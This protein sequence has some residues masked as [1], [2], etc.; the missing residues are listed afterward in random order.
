MLRSRVDLWCLLLAAWVNGSFACGDN[1]SAQPVQEQ[2]ACISHFDYDKPHWQPKLAA[3]IRTFDGRTDHRVAAAAFDSVRHSGA[4]NTE[5]AEAI[6]LQLQHQAPLYQERDKWHVLRLRA[7]AFVTLAEIGVPQSALPMLTDALMYVDE[8][9]Q[10]VEFGAAL[11]AAASLGAA[12]RP[13]IPGIL[14]LYTQRFAEEEFSLDHYQTEFTP[15]SATTVQTEATLALGQ[16]A[17]AEDRDA[18]KVLQAIATRRQSMD[19]RVVSAANQALTLIAARTD[20]VTERPPLS[21]RLPQTEQPIALVD[22][23]DIYFEDQDGRQRQLSATIDKPTL[24]TFFYSRCQN[25]GKCSVTV[26]KL[27]RLQ[28]QLLAAEMLSDINILAATF[29]PQYDTNK[30]LKRYAADRGFQFSGNAAVIRFDP[31]GHQRIIEQLDIAVGYN[32]GWVNSHGVELVLLDSTGKLA[33]RYSVNMWDN[34]AVLN[35]ITDL[36]S[37]RN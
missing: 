6:S 29:E 36:L 9:M 20:A 31:Q 11:R 4:T 19:P 30:R 5:L 22:F 12:A 26:A 10:S 32:A 14:E 8:R 37:L 18:I 34:S 1:F 15:Q 35:D 7:Y 24:L 2:L 25:D 13:Y 27:A 28:K 23:Q 21:P 3:I 33:Q 17:L 16:I